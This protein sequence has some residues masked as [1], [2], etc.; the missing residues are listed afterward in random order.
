[1]DKFRHIFKYILVFTNQQGVAKG[2]MTL[3]DLEAIHAKMLSALKGQID[4]IYTCVDSSEVQPNCRKPNTKMFEMAQADFPEIDYGKSLMV[5]DSSSDM[6]F[7]KR[8]GATTVLVGPI[9]LPFL[10]PDT[11]HVVA[12]L[13]ELV[14]RLVVQ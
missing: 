13:S 11:D 10:P 4:R 6:V 5:G 9:D 14:D 2:V 1:M 3:D 7:G 12:S 8:V